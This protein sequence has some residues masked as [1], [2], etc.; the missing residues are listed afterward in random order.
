MS[1]KAIVWVKENFDIDERA[2]K[3]FSL[4]ENSLLHPKK[5]Y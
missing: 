1:E 3:I 4:L 2:K 5:N